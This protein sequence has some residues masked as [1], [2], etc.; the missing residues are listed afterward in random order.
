MKFTDDVSYLFLLGQ[1]I[2]FCLLVAF[3]IFLAV[4]DRRASKRLDEEEKAQM[5]KNNADT[6]KE[7]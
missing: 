5:A 4:S 7:L 3:V 2:F 6:S 1:I